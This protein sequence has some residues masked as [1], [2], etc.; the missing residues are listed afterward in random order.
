MT[1]KELIKLLQG[2]PDE[3]LIMRTVQGIYTVNIRT[4]DVYYVTVTREPKRGVHTRREY[5]ST[6]EREAPHMLVLTVG[7]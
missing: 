4:S 1:V 3:T 7:D 6:E 2:H 5:M